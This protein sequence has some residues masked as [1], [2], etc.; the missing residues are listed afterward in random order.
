[1]VVTDSVANYKLFRMKKLIYLIGLGLMFIVGYMVGHCSRQCPE[2]PEAKET[3]EVKVK[4][5][6]IFPKDTVVKKA[7]K[8]KAKKIIPDLLK[9]QKSYRVYNDTL[10]LP[11]VTLYPIDTVDGEILSKQIGYNLK[12]PLRIIDTVEINKTITTEK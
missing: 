8:P 6:T 10:D 3:I 7:Y 5:D 9:P 4:R 12:V 11:E 1:M 2:C